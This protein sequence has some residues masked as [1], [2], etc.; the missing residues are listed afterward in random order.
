M[1]LGGTAGKAAPRSLPLANSATVAGDLVEQ[2]AKLTG[3]GAV[4]Q[5]FLTGAG[6]PRGLMVLAAPDPPTGATAVA[7]NGQAS[8]S[9]TPPV[10]NG[11]APISSYLVTASPGGVTATGSSSPVVVTGLT[12]GVTYTFT[13][14]ASNAAGT[15]PD[16]APS[17]AVTPMANWS[18]LGAKLAGADAFGFEVA[19]SADGNTALVGS[20]GDNGQVGGAW[21]M[22]RSG[23]AWV[24]GPKLTGAGEAGEGLFGWIVSLSSDGNT[25]LVGGPGDNNY[26]GAVWVFTRSDGVWDQ[27]GQ[28]LTGSVGAG[29]FGFALELSGDG[30]TAVVGSPFEDAARIFVRSGGSWSQQGQKLTGSG[31]S[32]DSLFGSSVTL[33]G[34]G[35]TAL[36]SG[37]GDNTQVGAVWVFSGAGGTWAQ[38]GGKLTGSGESGRGT[39]GDSVALSASGSTA[40]V[41]GSSDGA[42]VGAAW[43]FTRSGTAWAQQG[44]KLTAPFGTG[45]AS[46]GYDV[47]LSSDGSTALIGGPDDLGSKGAAWTFL[48]SGTTWTQPGGKL[49]GTGELGAGGFGTAVALSADG[50]IGLIGGSD[51]DNGA[52]A[53]WTFVSPPPAAPT[54]VVA[55]AVLGGA[56]IAF[57]APAGP[58]DAFS[59]TAQPGGATVTGAASPIVVTGLSSTTA[60]NFTVTASNIGGVGPPSAASNAVTPLGLPSVPLGVSAAGADGQ[61]TVTFTPPASDGGL[62]V[63]SY[64]VTA[65]PGGQS[66]SGLGSPITVH[67]LTNGVSYTFT[68]TAT[69]GIGTGPPSAS[70][71]PVTPLAGP[72]R[73]GAEP[74][75]PSPRPPVPEPPIAMPRAPIP[76]H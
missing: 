25:A 61:A 30:N 19:L 5:S 26:A 8:V 44:P 72:D 46:F 27:Q 35:T 34:D 47:A 15:S 40:L 55:T 11:G 14:S 1:V 10:S 49:T 48:R 24:Q 39:F 54:G 70:S 16:S 73:A 56:S 62:P 6:G 17:N 74:P 43:V 71:T 58:V 32:G 12:N 63:L 37:P 13:V 51:D 41:G 64:T 60:Y 18:Q 45:T 23:D 31:E 28:K 38:Q 22:T 7:G 59:V 2:G 66:A 75:N 50:A 68:V 67:G 53:T 3:A 52:G 69:N 33:S 57:G 20:P 4:T 9:F 36:V 21:V 76:G 29:A 65:S 42:G